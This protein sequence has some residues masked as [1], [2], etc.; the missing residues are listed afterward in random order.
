MGVILRLDGGLP[1]LA[2]VPGLVVGSVCGDIAT[3]RLPLTSLTVL[4]GRDDLRAIEAATLAYPTMDVA[5]PSA[6]VDQVW[7][8]TPAFTGANVIVAVIDTGIDFSH[9]DFDDAD[10]ST[11]I[12][13][14]WDLN[15]TGTPPSGFTY[16]AEWSSAQIDAGT[17]TERDYN[18]HG[19]HVTGMAAGDGSASG[20][21]IPR[22]WPTRPTS[23]SPRPMTTRTA[24]FP[25]TGPSTP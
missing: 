23:S 24:V 13:N 3:A 16:G 15:G 8:G 4:A 1:D 12:L 17:A 10:G 14:I 21:A 5:I 2:D 11:R 6:H 22:G 20:G 18:G 25:R 19:S 7:A 9:E